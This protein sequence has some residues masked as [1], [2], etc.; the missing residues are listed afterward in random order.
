MPSQ[1]QY[2]YC[3]SKR[4]KIRN[5]EINLRPDTRLH[6]TWTAF[7]VKPSTRS[8]GPLFGPRTLWCVLCT[9]TRRSSPGDSSLF[10]DGCLL[11]IDIPS[12]QYQTRSIHSF[13]RLLSPAFASLPSKSFISMLPTFAFAAL[14]SALVVR[15]V[16]CVQFDTAWN[17]YAFGGSSDVN[18]GQN[19]TWA[20]ECKDL[21]HSS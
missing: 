19:T 5:L 9:R 12:F 2:I 4:I 7:P 11:V 1:S 14:A 18:L 20:C 17:L 21:L 16:P 3:D 15:A 13:R 8:V 6:A 10:A